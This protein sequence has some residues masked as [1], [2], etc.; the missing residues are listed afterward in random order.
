MLSGV[1]EVEVHLPGIGMSE[2]AELQ[3]D[4]HQTPQLAM[5]E[6]QIDAIPFIA[7]AQASLPSDEREIAAEF[8]QEGFELL[9]QGFFEI[10]F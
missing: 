9:D 10:A 2:F 7:D 5:E 1:I 4:H 3:V 6:E 8:Q